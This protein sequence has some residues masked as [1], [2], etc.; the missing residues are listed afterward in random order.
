LTFPPGQLTA[1]LG[2][3]GCGKTTL[4]RII[5][6]LENADAG[7]VYLDGEDA[8][9]IHVRDRKIGFVFQHY[10]LFK[11]M[12]VADNIA[13]GLRVQP[14]K[15]RPSEDQISKKVKQLLELV[16]LDHLGGRHPSQL[17]GGQRQRIALAR[18][19]AIDPRVLL[20]DEPFGALDAKVRKDLRGWIRRLHDELHFTSIF[21]THDQDEALEIADQVVLMNHGRIEQIGKPDDVYSNPATAFAYEFLGD[22]NRIDGQLLNGNFHTGN[23]ILA[24]RAYETYSDTN[25]VAYVRPQ[26]FDIGPNDGTTGSINA[27]LIRK[28]IVGSTVHAE[29][30]RK[31]T[32]DYL[33]IMIPRERFDNLL[34]NPGDRITVKPSRL[35]I[36]TGM[37]SSAE[38]QVTQ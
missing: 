36:F 4:L 38:Q 9:N 3:S 37:D 5:A 31:D 1:L 21:V 22:V 32:D 26:E 16:Q 33:D 15:L 18:A 14:R 35:R 29:V 23:A 13:F 12:S 7:T 27:T 17:S 30:R 25:A 8:T 20:L 2:P 11:H 10:A 19:L 24:A 28:R 34:L 6:G